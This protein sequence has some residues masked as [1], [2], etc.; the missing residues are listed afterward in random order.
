MNIAITKKEFKEDVLKSMHLTVVQFKTEWNGA[1][2]I[3]APIYEDLAKSYNGHVRFYTIDADKEKTVLKKYGITETPAILFFQN[4]NVVDYA[5]GLISRN[6]LI[7]KIETA[8]SQNK[9]SNNL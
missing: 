4:G 6:T 1:C 3:I 5:F 9:T 7:S 8:L 2:Q